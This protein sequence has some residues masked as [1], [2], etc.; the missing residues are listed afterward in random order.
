MDFQLLPIFPIRRTDQ[1]LSPFDFTPELDENFFWGPLLPSK[2]CR[3]HRLKQKN[4]FITKRRQPQKWSEIVEIPRMFSADDLHVQEDGDY[5][6]I[7]ASNDEGGRQSEMI[8]RIL[9]PDDVQR[10]SLKTVWLNDRHALVLRGQRKMKSTKE[11]K[12][13]PLVELSDG[14]D[15]DLTSSSMDNIEKEKIHELGD[16]S[17][18]KDQMTSTDERE[19]KTTKNDKTLN[20]GQSEV[21]LI[22]DGKDGNAT[23]VEKRQDPGVIAKPYRISHDV[24]GFNEDEVNV[25]VN[26]GRVKVTG[27]HQGDDEERSFVRIFTLPD[28]VDS[29]NLKWNWDDENSKIMFDAPLI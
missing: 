4:P 24:A 27:A 8:Q 25:T 19:E 7:R 29:K 21:T 13:I 26:E 18:E 28:F 16:E 11:V 14:S 10:D 15:M 1:L 9:I 20:E 3:L 17:S 6:T 23:Q 22:I 12:T 5:V 2:R